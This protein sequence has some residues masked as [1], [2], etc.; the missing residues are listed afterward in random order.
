MAWHGSTQLN[1]RC[2]SEAKIARNTGPTAVSERAQVALH[3]AESQ[4]GRL[5]L[6]FARSPATAWKFGIVVMIDDNFSAAVMESSPLPRRRCCCLASQ[7]R[8]ENVAAT[9]L[10]WLV[11]VSAARELRVGIV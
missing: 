4:Y 11:L 9:G 3:T 7:P 1:R 5:C 10:V 2:A 6:R 8:I